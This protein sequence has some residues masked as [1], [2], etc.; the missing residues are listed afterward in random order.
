MYAEAAR[1][2][3]MTSFGAKLTFQECDIVNHIIGAS[4]NNGFEIASL[5]ISQIGR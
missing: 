4:R 1:H 5:A 2:H 3:R